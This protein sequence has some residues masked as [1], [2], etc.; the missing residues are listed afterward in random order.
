MQDAMKYREMNKTL[1]LEAAA[2]C[3]GLAYYQKKLFGDPLDI[4]MFQFTGWKFDENE[5]WKEN[6]V[7]AYTHPKGVVHKHIK[8]RGSLTYNQ[9]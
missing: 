1:L 4:E 3:H 7:L 8:Q 2:S 9:E 6:D 5:R